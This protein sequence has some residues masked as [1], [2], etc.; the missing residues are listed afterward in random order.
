MTHGTVVALG[1]PALVEGYRLVGAVV[2]TAETAAAVCEAWRDLPD[3]TALV[4]L[5]SSA[6]RALGT[7]AFA[8]DAPLTVVI[9]S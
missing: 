1:E 2:R 3:G 5:T 9:P 6:A 4:V 7:R 8:P